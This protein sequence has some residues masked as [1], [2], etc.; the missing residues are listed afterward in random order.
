[1]TNEQLHANRSCPFGGGCRDCPCDGECRYGGVARA[2]ETG[3]AGDDWPKGLRN[4]NPNMLSEEF[5]R[6]EAALALRQGQS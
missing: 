2:L 4:S 1:M 6:F 5:A 3:K